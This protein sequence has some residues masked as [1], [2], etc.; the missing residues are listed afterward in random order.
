MS[1]SELEEPEMDLGGEKF[2][3]S[4]STFRVNICAPSSSSSVRYSLCPFWSL[5]SPSSLPLNSLMISTDLPG[6][7]VM[8]S[9]KS[10]SASSKVTNFDLQFLNELRGGIFGRLSWSSFRV[11]VTW[12]GR[13]SSVEDIF[14]ASS[15]Q[16]ASRLGVG[17]FFSGFLWLLGSTARSS[18]QSDTETSGFARLFF[19]ALGNSRDTGSGVDAS[20]QTSQ[21]HGSSIN[22]GSI[23]AKMTADRWDRNDFYRLILN[24]K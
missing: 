13:V 14:L 20:V 19:S 11:C 15:S 21:S 12:A 10:R 8:K 22:L 18:T 2:D 9:W 16:T 1:D 7:V 17:C 5:G 24:Q 23:V 6:P 3:L 4:R